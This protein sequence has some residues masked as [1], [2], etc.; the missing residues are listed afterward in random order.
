L[1]IGTRDLPR[2]TLN[3]QFSHQSGPNRTHALASRSCPRLFDGAQGR[4]E[5][6][7]PR[8]AHSTDPTAQIPRGGDC[9]GARRK[10]AGRYHWRPV[11]HR[12]AAEPNTNAP[13]MWLPR[14]TSPSLRTSTR[15]AVW[16]SSAHSLLVIAGIRT[17]LY[18]FQPSSASVCVVA[19]NR[20]GVDL[21]CF[22]RGFDSHR[23]PLKQFCVR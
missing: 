11:A 13:S 8:T 23:S 17:S 5:P 3:R 7:E 1:L 20:A 9:G 21:R 18:V 14:R 22:G 16:S 15:P 19:A 10:A 2:V 6:V 12:R 4:R